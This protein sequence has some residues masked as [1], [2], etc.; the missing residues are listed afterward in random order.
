MEAMQVIKGQGDQEGHDQKF[1][2][3][4]NTEERLCFH[5]RGSLD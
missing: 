4:I 1:K 3:S 2:A 5:P